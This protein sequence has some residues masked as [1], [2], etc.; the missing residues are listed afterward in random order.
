[1]H[2]SCFGWFLKWK[3]SV[4]RWKT[5]KNRKGE[6]DVLEEEKRKRSRGR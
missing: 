2:Q 3:K 4:E 1:M 5:K 6:N